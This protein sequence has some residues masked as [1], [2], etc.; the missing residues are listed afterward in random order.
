MTFRFELKILMTYIMMISLLGVLFTS[1]SSQG[2]F[3]DSPSS[4]PDVN[5][6]IFNSNW[7]IEKQEAVNPPICKP[8]IPDVN[9]PFLDD[10]G[11]FG[12]TIGW[13]NGI[14]GLQF[15]SIWLVILFGIP[16]AVVSII[17]VVRIL[18]GN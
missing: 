11:C 16:L 13:I 2:I 9:I 15:N 6:T 5:Y 14:R 10:V 12:A 7:T 1:A 18:R 17:M 3:A 4:T 8:V